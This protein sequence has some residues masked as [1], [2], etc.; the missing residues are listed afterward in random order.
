MSDNIFT[1]VNYIR[2]A[3]VFD[4]EV[5]GQTEVDV[6]GAGASGSHVVFQLC[7]LGVK[8]IHVY[9]FDNVESHNICNQIYR[10]CDVGKPKVEALKE[11]VKEFSNIDITV[12][13]EELTEKSPKLNGEYVFVLTDTMSSR[14]DIV[15]NCIVDNYKTRVCIETRMSS[16]EGRMYCFYPT[17][18][19]SMERWY[20]T[21]Y[22]NEEAERSPCGSKISVGS[23]A[24][25]LASMS[26]WQFIKF[27]QFQEG[28]TDD[29]PEFELFFNTKPFT[30]LNM[31]SLMANKQN[32]TNN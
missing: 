16:S 5:F 21:L 25:Y 32:K 18:K 11:I 1:N 15:T 23:T 27:V 19:Q 17:S 22:S 3:P 20:S 8:N 26:V 10:P 31:D 7:K 2:Q 14:K 24:S 13:N 9:D 12:H 29:L 4:P 28:K 30:I 6:I